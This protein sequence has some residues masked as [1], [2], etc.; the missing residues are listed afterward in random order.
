MS[1]WKVGL[2]KPLF[3]NGSSSDP[4]NCRPI[5]STCIVCKI[6]ESVIKDA[7]LLYLD[8]HRLITND[9]NGFLK[10]RST[11]TNL[12]ECVNDWTISLNIRSCVDIL[13]L[14]FDKAF[15]V[16]SFPKLIHKLKSFGINGSLLCCISSFLNGRSQKVKIGK[17]VLPSLSLVSGVPQ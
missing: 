5:S 10:R 7:M 3:K 4:N 6:F 13:Y 14:D 17:F 15:D 2:V 9:Q 12:L 11:V 8:S 1:E 16:V